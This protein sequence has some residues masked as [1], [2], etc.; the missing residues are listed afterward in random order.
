MQNQSNTM[1]YFSNI[2]I[3]LKSHEVKQNGENISLSK[4]EFELL[5]F[6]AQNRTK[7]LS[8]E[9]IYEVVWWES[10][11]DFVF[12]KTIDVYVGYL[13]KKLWKEVI[14]TVKGFWFLIP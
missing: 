3:N 10:G 13:R 9:E 11:N 2:E 5:K 4:L 8:R 1:I 6:L 12:S 7:A 14:E